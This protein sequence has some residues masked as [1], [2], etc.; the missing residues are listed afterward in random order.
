MSAA[1]YNPGQDSVTLIL[2]QPVTLKPA[3]RGVL[4]K[5]NNPSSNGQSESTITDTS[6]QA[7]QSTGYGQPDGLLVAQ[8]KAR[9]SWL[10]PF[11]LA[12]RLARARQV[13]HKYAN[14]GDSISRGF[15]NSISRLVNAVFPFH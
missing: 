7:L 12:G 14:L 15:H 1:V 6:G 8:F 11:S 9:G 3:S 4:F 5:V 13:Q 2:A 10:N